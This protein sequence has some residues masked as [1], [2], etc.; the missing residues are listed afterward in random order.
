MHETLYKTKNESTDA[1]KIKIHYIKNL[2]VTILQMLFN[3]I[4]RVCEVNMCTI[5]LCHHIII[6]LSK[7]AL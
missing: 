6:T 3:T 2:S 5:S 1:I 4:S 7:H